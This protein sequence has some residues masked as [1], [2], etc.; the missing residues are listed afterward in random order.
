MHPL[1]SGPELHSKDIPFGPQVEEKI[2]IAMDDGISDDS[3]SSDE[4][5][6][7]LNPP[8]VESGGSPR[9]S[10]DSEDQIGDEMTH[11]LQGA[12]KELER[13]TEE[14]LDAGPSII[15][16]LAIP[17]GLLVGAAITGGTTY[18]LVARVQNL[19]ANAAVDGDLVRW[20]QAARTQVYDACYHGCNDCSDPEY[21]YN[22]CQKTARVD[23][24]GVVCDGNKMWNWAA[25]DRY[26][27]RC[28]AA[29]GRLLMGEELERLKQSYRNQLAIIIL[30]VLGG[31]LGGVVTYL[32]WRRLTTSKKQREAANPSS[33][34]RTWSIRRP[35]TW[36][37]R[38]RHS[39]SSPTHSQ[40]RKPRLAT[41]VTALFAVSK[42]KPAHAYAC[43]GHDPAWNQYFISTNTTAPAIS[44]VVHG[45][46]SDCRTRQDCSTRKCTKSC[47][48]SSKGKSTCI[49]TCTNICHTEVYTV[50][51]PKEYV[52]AVLPRVR[53]CGFRLVD[54]LPSGASAHERVGNA[55]L[56][57]GLWVRLSVS[58]FNVT[59]R[60]E[61]DEV[62]WC[63]HGIGG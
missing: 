6:S 61:T 7:V 37:L 4:Y 51:T 54:A 8:T 23:I 45:W 50:K 43:T 39:N 18:A 52:D 26:P 11:H 3:R 17:I 27:E 20:K 55:G 48:I 31:V 60:D 10:S 9:S 1:A 40:H 24:K 28:L 15:P 30:T 63:L 42:A 16:R 2:D 5:G 13:E 59:R 49:R 58:G 44:G 34:S 25:A 33:G 53:A 29:V 14:E 32:L 22:A 19:I 62:V 56:E 57:R 38:R 35:A 41:I 12:D 46:L 47:S 36:S 21:A